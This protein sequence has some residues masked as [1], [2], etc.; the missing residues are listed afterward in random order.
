M[1][2]FLLIG[3]IVALV[4]LY[5]ARTYSHAIVFGQTSLI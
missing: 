4:P 2:N 5:T 3:L 1:R